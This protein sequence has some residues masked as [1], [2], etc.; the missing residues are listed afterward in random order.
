MNMFSKYGFNCLVFMFIWLLSSCNES[1]ETDVFTLPSKSRQALIQEGYKSYQFRI[2]G[3]IETF[4]NILHKAFDDTVVKYVFQDEVL[5]RVEV[6]FNIHKLDSGVFFH[7][8]EKKGFVKTNP[9]DKIAKMAF[10]EPTKK[11]HYEV[12]IGKSEVDFVHY[13]ARLAYPPPITFDT[14]SPAK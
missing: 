1:K 9:I 3:E 7:N 12:Y 8:C 4:D 5:E 13:F 10:I 11:I 14:V 6:G 2:G